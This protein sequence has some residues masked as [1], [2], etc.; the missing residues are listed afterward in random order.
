MFPQLSL[1]WDT[2]VEEGSE[3]AS[4]G[5]QWRPEVAKDSRGKEAGPRAQNPGRENVRARKGVGR[6]MMKGDT[7]IKEKLRR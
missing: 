5:I 4:S 1:P 6:Q 2:S 7:Q 3:K